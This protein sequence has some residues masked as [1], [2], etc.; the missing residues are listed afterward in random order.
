M[1]VQVEAWSDALPELLKMFP[2]LWDDVAVDKERFVAECDTAKYAALDSLGILHLV[3]AR[4]AKRLVGYFL[5]FVQENAHYK[6]Q[7][8]MAFTDMYFLESQYRRGA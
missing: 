7:G 8:L 1:Q 6:G 2:L 4:E 5:V 3:T